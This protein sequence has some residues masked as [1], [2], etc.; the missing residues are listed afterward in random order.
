[1]QRLESNEQDIKQDKTRLVNLPCY[2]EVLTIA[3]LKTW[4]PCGLLTHL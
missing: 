3:F 1:M 4:A 2:R